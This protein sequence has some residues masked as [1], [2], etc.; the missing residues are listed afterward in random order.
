MTLRG[1]GRFVCPGGGHVSEN[2]IKFALLVAFGIGF[3]GVAAEPVEIG[4][5]VIDSCRIV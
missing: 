5:T 1:P 2:R 4:V 3:S